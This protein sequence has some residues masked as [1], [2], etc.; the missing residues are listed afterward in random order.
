MKGKFKNIGFISTRI[1]GTDGVSLEIEKW[2]KVLERNKYNCYYFAGASDRPPKKCFLV[3][4][5]HFGH[6]KIMKIRKGCFGKEERS[7]EIS[8]L[9]ENLKNQL[10][11]KIQQFVEKFDIDLIIPENALAIPMNIPLGLAITDFIAET[12]FPTIAHHHDFY[13]ERNRFLVNSVNDYLD[14]A[15]PPDLP[16]IEHVVINSIASE[17]LSHRKG[18][19]NTIIP[20]VYDFA[21]PPSRSDSHCPDLRKRIGLKENDLFVLQPTR[22]VPRKCIETS[23][24]LVHQMK[25][26]NPVLVISHASGDEGSSYYENIKEYAKNLGVKI[27][28]IEKIIGP[29]RMEKG[30]GKIYTIGDVYLCA[31]LVTYPSSYEGFGNA[32][33]E[34]IYYR[35]PVVV[36]RYP[37]YIVDI[38]PKRFD[39]I[40]INRFVT[41]ETIKKI[42]EILKNEKRREKM[43]EKNYRVALEYFSYEVL[44]NSLKDTIEELQKG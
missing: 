31:D 10:K 22:V 15:F 37:I 5:A 32:F 42:R 12:G 18:I 38:E 13:W 30:E 26:K 9:I 36:N 16:S 35:K 2:A 14:R 29:K 24:E 27:V 23:V 17:E 41:K 6:P 3:K 4:E 8:K 28:S 25:L 19:S 20:N 7:P 34:A 40:A 43:V 11:K 21:S 1:A 39:L 33:L 44:E